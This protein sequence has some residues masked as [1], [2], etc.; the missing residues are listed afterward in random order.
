MQMLIKLIFLMTLNLM[1]LR[2]FIR[3]HYFVFDFFT[4][5]FILQNQPTFL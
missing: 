5:N 3:Y 4:I 2:M 1:P